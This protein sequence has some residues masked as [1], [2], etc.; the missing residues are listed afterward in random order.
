MF[1]FKFYAPRRL[2]R[3]L[4]FFHCGSRFHLKDWHANI[5]LCFDLKKGEG[6]RNAREGGLRS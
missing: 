5:K 3:L 6:G 1:S 2:I 4:V